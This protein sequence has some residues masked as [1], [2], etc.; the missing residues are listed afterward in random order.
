MIQGTSNK[1]QRTRA[2]G[3][4]NAATGLDT[5]LFDLYDAY[6]EARREVFATGKVPDGTPFKGRTW[7]SS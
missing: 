1:R 4:A 2:A 6:G 5:D 3:E 7:R